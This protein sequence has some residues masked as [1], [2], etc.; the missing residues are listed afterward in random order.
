MFKLIH[1]DIRKVKNMKIMKNV[2]LW[3]EDIGLFQLV[4]NAFHLKKHNI[5]T[6][7]VR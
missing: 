1:P 4:N 2:E 3:D 5:I 6:G 7:S